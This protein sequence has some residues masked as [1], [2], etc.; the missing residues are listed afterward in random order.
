MARE[1]TA[2]ATNPILDG[3]R[4]NRSVVTEHGHR[5]YVHYAHRRSMMVCLLVPTT[6]L[7][8]DSMGSGGSPGSL[9]KIPD[10]TQPLPASN[11]AANHDI[12]R[13]HMDAYGPSHIWY[14]FTL[15]RRW[16][17]RF[18]HRSRWSTLNNKAASICHVPRFIN[19]SRPLGRS[20]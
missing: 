16:H 19:S 9:R 20:K 1:L 18:I 13:C 14:V 2:F 15:R 7:V 12:S 11:R 8:P 4:C 17:D 3:L 5:F 6:G 10:T